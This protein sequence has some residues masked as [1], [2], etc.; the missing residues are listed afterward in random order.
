MIGEKEIAEEIVSAV[1]R[2]LYGRADYDSLWDST[3]AR[4][5]QE[6]REELRAEVEAILSKVGR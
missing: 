6:I 4:T 1:L 2:N 3:D 5:Q